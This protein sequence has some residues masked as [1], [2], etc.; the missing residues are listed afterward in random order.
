MSGKINNRTLLL[1]LLV[2]IT[3]FVISRFTSLKKPDR[4]LK[5]NLIQIDTSRVSSILLYPEAENG[6]QLEF[7]KTNNSWTVSR[8]GISAPA[9]AGAVKNTLSELQNLK[10]EQLVALSPE[11]WNEYQVEDS[12][13]TR[14]VLKEGNK[15]TLDLIVGR[16]QYQPPPQ[17]SYSPYAQN[18]GIGKTYVRLSGE[19]EVYSV[20]GFLSMSLNQEFSR[21]R[22]RTISRMNSSG[23]TR[24]VFDY[25]ADSGFVAQR[26]EAGWMVSGILADSSSMA[27][28]L[29]RSTNKTHSR[30]ADG[31]QPGP[32]PDYSLVFEGD[33]M[34]PQQIKAY[35]QKNGSIVLNSSF[36]PDTWFLFE[37]RDQ[38]MDLFPASGKLISG[39]N[40]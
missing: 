38:I 28:Y 16:F 19:N 27:K 23:I 36:N 33:N 29:Q 3:L 30:F 24:I 22:N 7:N 31:V 5:A 12:S 13:G 9:D 11:N 4:T 37:D 15:V 21:W 1:V 35:I 25:P 17:N 8:E 20:N 32:E 26:S 14:V 39:E 40:P 2:F 10:A 18:R 34:K 6:K